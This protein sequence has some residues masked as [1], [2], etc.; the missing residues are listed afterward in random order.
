MGSVGYHIIVATRVLKKGDPYMKTVPKIQPLITQLLHQHAVDLD[1]PAA[2]LW[3]AIPQ[4]EE[5]LVIER[6]DAAHLS[7]GFTREEDDQDYLLA[8]EIVF[9]TDENGWLPL[10]AF[11]GNGSCG[12]TGLAED[13]AQLIEQ[14]GWLAHG[15][16]LPDPPWLTH[17]E[18]PWTNAMA[19]DDNDLDLPGEEGLCAL[20][21]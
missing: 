4:R 12:I 19:E 14:A 9:F 11:P 1:D 21:Y 2:F 13:L 8:P 15:Q 17:H 5:R 6:I 20:P 7:I 10:R 18:V 3:L 16:K